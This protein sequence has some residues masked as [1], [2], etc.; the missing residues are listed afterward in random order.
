MYYIYHINGVKIGCTKQLDI[1]M[2]DQ[3]FTEWEILEEHTDIYEASNREIQL[4]KEYG[5]P[6]DDVL[7]FKSIENRLSGCAKGGRV[8]GNRHVES[9]HLKSISSL[10]GKKTWTNVRKAYIDWQCEHCNKKG[11]LKGNYSRWHGDNCK[12][13][14]TLTN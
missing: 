4:Q 12:H 14:E 3:G 6:V 8:A 5:L 13:K 9:G 2:R 11:K 1:R 10:G 7:Y